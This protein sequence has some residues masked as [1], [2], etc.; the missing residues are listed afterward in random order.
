L[1]PEHPD[2]FFSVRP[3]FSLAALLTMTAAAAAVFQPA[4]PAYHGCRFF[5]KHL[6]KP[7]V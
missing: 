7:A 6:D 5:T 3:L 1:H 2:G 4:T